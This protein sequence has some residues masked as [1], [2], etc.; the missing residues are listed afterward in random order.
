MVSAFRFRLRK[1]KVTSLSMK[2]ARLKMSRAVIFG[3]TCASGQAFLMGNGLLDGHALGKIAWFV[4]VTST[5]KRDIIGEKLE[6]GD[7]QRGEK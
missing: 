3:D 7:T 2:T 5:L 1:K 4:D 6:R